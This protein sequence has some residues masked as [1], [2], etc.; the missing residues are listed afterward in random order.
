[1]T[2]ELVSAGPPPRGP[3]AAAT[4]ATGT[5]TLSISGALPEG[6][7]NEII[8]GDDAEL[9]ARQVFK[10]IDAVL[11][12]AGA[13]R[14]D[15]VRITVYLTDMAD[16]PAVARARIEYFGEHTPAATLMQI[17]SLVVPEIKVE[18]EAI[19]IF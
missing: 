1:M 16:R 18:I 6:P 9:Q 15:I 11:T 7:E 17:T 8:G 3:Y 13:T 12:A 5:R 10:N 14:N 2:V 4:L 19:A